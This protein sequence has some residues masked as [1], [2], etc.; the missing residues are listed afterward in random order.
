ME[1]WLVT[2]D[3]GFKSLP[4]TLP[5]LGRFLRAGEWV[6]PGGGLPTSLMTACAAIR[7]MCHQDCVPSSA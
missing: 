7:A 5:G 3:T 6:Q 2:P 4:L 1:G